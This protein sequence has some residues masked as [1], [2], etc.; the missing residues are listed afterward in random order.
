V[1]QPV[2]V[3]DLCSQTRFAGPSLLVEHGVVSG[4]SVIIGGWQHPFGVLG[5]HT[6]HKRVFRQEDINFMTSVAHV[7]S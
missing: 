2:I 3:E 4:M 1:H 5:A 6:A 7:L